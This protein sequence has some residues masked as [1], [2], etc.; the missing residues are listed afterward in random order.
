VGSVVVGFVVCF[1]GVLLAARHHRRLG[2]LLPRDAPE[3]GL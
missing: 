2:A 3:P 1:A